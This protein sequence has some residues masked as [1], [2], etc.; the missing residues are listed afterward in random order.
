M[1]IVTVEG[2]T[3]QS[4]PPCRLRLFHDS[5]VE[6]SS[7][8]VDNSIAEMEVDYTFNPLQHNNKACIGIVIN[9]NLIFFLNVPMVIV[10]ILS[11]FFIQQRSLLSK[12]VH[13][14]M[15]TQIML[16]HHTSNVSNCCIQKRKPWMRK[17]RF[18]L[19]IKVVWNI[20][21]I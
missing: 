12:K 21:K 9:F 14:I 4:I 15:T 1:I 7:V 11:W 3:S 19:D 20:G 6:A 18:L 16:L 2:C 8:L 10:R 17:W 13:D 5:V